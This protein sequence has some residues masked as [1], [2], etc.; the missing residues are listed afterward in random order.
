MP[1]TTAAVVGAPEVG[2][3]VGCGVGLTVVGTAVAG[4]GV[5]T[6]YV[7]VGALEGD[8]VV[9]GDGLGGRT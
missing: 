6:G 7:V 5:L 2:R 3:A 9:S 1:A 8:L 4:P